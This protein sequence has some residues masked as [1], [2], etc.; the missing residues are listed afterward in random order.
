MATRDGKPA[1]DIAVDV[2]VV[3]AGPAGAAA[4]RAAAHAGAE[5]LLIDRLA[6]PRYKRCGGGLVYLSAAAAG[7]PAA[8]LAGVTRDRVTTVEVSH[9]LGRVSRWSPVRHPDGLRFVDRADFD[10]AL[11]D[12]ACRAGARLLAP[13]TLQRIRE[14]RT[15]VWLQLDGGPGV[16]A[17]VV[18]G[19]DGSAGRCAATVGVRSDRVDLGLESEVRLGAAERLWWRGR[20]WLD[21]S[22]VT[23]AAGAY[24]WAF[25]KGDHLT[26]G[27]IGDRTASPALRDYLRRV[28][29]RLDL[30]GAPLVS[31]GGHLTRCRAADSP[32]VFDGGRVLLAGDAAGLVEPWT[33]EGIS[34]ALRSGVLAGRSAAAMTRAPGA[35]HPGSR[36]AAVGATRYTRLLGD[37][38]VPELAAGA[39]LLARVGGRPGTAVA[40]LRTP[41]GR[42]AFERVIAGEASFSGFRGRWGRPGR[43]TRAPAAA[44]VPAW[45]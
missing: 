15:G 9:R 17:R 37:V 42:R 19:A 36:E 14:D 32:V 25:P 26:V 43:C 6:P 20:M 31:S 10:A 23:G 22:P 27:V 40:L 29:A 8:V 2:A 7:L 28:L 11:V 13:A 24:A 44:P 38:C 35:P 39:A 18:V 30:A 33:R 4:A 41:P 21:L 1:S 34:F 45:R 12:Q 5:V 16:R 3:G